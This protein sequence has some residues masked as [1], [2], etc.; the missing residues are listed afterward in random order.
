VGEVAD[1]DRHALAEAPGVTPP[2]R[3]DVLVETGAL[4]EI[5]ATIDSL[6]SE[7]IAAIKVADITDEARGA[8]VDLA[9]FVAWRES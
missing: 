3:L 1:Q 5:E 8:L 6:T 9:Q 4:D 7:A 2:V